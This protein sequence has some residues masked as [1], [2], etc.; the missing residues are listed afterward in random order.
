MTSR[1]RVQRVL[2]G[3]LPDRLPF[4]FWMDRD[5][6]AELDRRYGADFR[7]THYGADVIEGFILLNFWPGLSANTVDDGK[8]VWQVEPMVRDIRE[9]V[10]H[11]MPDPTDEAVYSDLRQK[12]AQ[13]PD[14]AIFA[15][16]GGPFS[17]LEPLRLAENVFYDV[18]D[19]PDAVHAILKRAEEVFTEAAR[20][21]CAEDIDVLYIAHDICSRNG[22][23]MS[24]DM[25]R[26][27]H[28]DYLRGMVE[29]AHAA[30]KKV[31]HHTDGYVMDILDLF[32][33]Y[34][35]DGINPL[36]PR[37]HDSE[38][39][40]RRSSGR[41]MVYGGGDNCNIIPDGT[42]D[43]VRAHVRRQFEVLGAN[44]GYIFSTH[45]IPSHCPDENLDAMV[46][47]IKDCR[48]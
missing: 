8:T 33:E 44:G 30:G 32:I 17:I 2:S 31:F 48:Y 12:R 4:N 26:E 34:G 35:F 37:Y 11:P 5:R 18:I 22:A 28:F 13:W 45:D 9:A 10:D 43:E 46:E 6:M 3:Q 7:L 38:E 20:R 42:P 27:F 40:V 1:E 19:H 25:L 24:P 47:A 36:E 41:L 14:K 39:F 23:M 29:A 16:T 15:L 21:A